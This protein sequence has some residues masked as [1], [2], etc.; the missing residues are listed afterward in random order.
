MNNTF[1]GNDVGNVMCGKV[2][3]RPDLAY[4]FNIII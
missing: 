2:C 1:C 3:S 4:A